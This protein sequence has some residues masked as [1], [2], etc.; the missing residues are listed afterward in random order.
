[1]KLKL[2]AAWFALSWLGLAIYSYGLTAP[3]LWLVSWPWFIN[4]QTLAWTLIYNNRPLAAGC[5][6][7]LIVSLFASYQFLLNSLEKSHWGQQ[8]NFPISRWLLIWLMLIWPTIL[9]MNFLSYDVFN[10]LFNAKMVAVYQANP[11]LNVAL[12][13]ATDP[14]LRFMHNVH[15][16]APYGYGW[17]LFSFLPYLLSLGKFS[18]GWIIF[19]LLAVGSLI[20]TLI[21]L[22]RLAKIQHQ[23]L[24]LTKIALLALNP[25][26][27]LEII[28]NSHNDLWMIWPALISYE[29]ILSPKLSKKKILLAGILLAFSIST[30]FATLALVPIWLVL[31]SRHFINQIKWPWLSKIQALVTNHWPLLSSVALFL[32]LFLSQSKQFLPWYL[33]WSLVWLPLID[34]KYW[35]TILLTFSITSLI[36]YYPWLLVNA[37]PELVIS[38]QKIITWLIPSL[39]AGWL[40][41]N[42][43]SKKY[44]WR[45]NRSLT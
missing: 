17:T 38:E 16:P 39:Y 8:T 21:T 15:T 12:D 20:G 14:W 33:S 26:L 23:P 1:M 31:V 4:F 5:F 11:H 24:T 45:S 34:V 40:G 37:Y 25:L 35:I 10:Y 29:L 36:R 6:L 22:I 44:F 3:N 42:W 7:G 27:I 30:K 18:L 28:V 41:I 19:R 9:A 13:F 32:P 43:L 2:S